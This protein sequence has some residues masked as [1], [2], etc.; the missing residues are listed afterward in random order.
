VPP[1]S[2]AWV[3]EQAGQPERA[4]AVAAALLYGRD[5]GFTWDDVDALYASLPFKK[6]P[7]GKWKETRPMKEAEI[8]RWQIA[9]RIEAL[10]PPRPE[11]SP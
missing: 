3:R 10:L 8:R 1:A 4:H 5:F 6:D 11:P 9:E 7:S 2:R